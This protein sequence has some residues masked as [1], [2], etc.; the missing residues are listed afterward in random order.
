MAGKPGTTLLSGTTEVLEEQKPVRLATAA[1][2]GEYTSLVGVWV[3][4]DASNT[5]A[6]CAVGGSK[7]TTEAKKTLKANLGI[8]I[9][10]KMPP[11]FIEVNSLEAIWVDVE[12][13]KD[14]VS[15]TAVQA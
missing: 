9:E 13:A 12:K 6:I 15:W 11:I 14:C 7:A 8:I 3:S 5:G 10:K 2:A 4:C 1:Q